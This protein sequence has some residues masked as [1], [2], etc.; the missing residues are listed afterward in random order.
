MINLYPRLS[1]SKGRPA[2]RNVLR[3]IHHFIDTALLMAVYHFRSRD[4]KY[5]CTSGTSFNNVRDTSSFTETNCT[6]LA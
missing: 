6:I 4:E 3:Y 5:R 2:N 1:L